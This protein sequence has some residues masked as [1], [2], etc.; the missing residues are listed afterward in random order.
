[1]RVAWVSL[2][3]ARTVLPNAAITRDVELLPALRTAKFETVT[4]DVVRL[5]HDRL[6][7]APLEK[8]RHENSPP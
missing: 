8:T 1:V 4:D 2:A 5:A 3:A 6:R 7:L